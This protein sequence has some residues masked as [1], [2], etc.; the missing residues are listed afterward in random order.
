MT[1]SKYYKL[2]HRFQ[3]VYQSLTSIQQVAKKDI[4]R[5][6]MVAHEKL[7]MKLPLLHWIPLYFIKAIVI[8]VVQTYHC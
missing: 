4:P 8:S 1:L 3:Y 5:G 6:C 7:A 2:I